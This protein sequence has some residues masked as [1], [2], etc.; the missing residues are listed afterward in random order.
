VGN[1]AD[2]GEDKKHGLG[3]DAVLSKRTKYKKF[4]RAYE[5]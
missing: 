5:R 1:F 2:Y 3:D 4:A